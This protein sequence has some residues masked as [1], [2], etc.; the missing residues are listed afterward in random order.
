MFARADDLTNE[1]SI[2]HHEMTDRSSEFGTKGVKE[3][4]LAHDI[5]AAQPKVS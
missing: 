5:F 2:G 4:R 3:E 1:E